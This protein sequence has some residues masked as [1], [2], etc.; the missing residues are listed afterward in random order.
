MSWLREVQSYE[1]Q[2][3]KHIEQGVKLYK[4][5]GAR[6]AVEN[7]PVWQWNLIFHL[8][9]PDIF[10]AIAKIIPTNP[11]HVVSNINPYA[12]IGEEV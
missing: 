9:D 6:E 11:L 3:P 12:D 10:E 4:V 1:I 2:Y 7:L 8:A 5:L